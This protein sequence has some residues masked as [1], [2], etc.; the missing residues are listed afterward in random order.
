M[1]EARTY[2]LYTLAGIASARDSPVDS[3]GSPNSTILTHPS[4]GEGALKLTLPLELREPRKRLAEPEEPIGDVELVLRLLP[5]LRQVQRPGGV[6]QGTAG[7][8]KLRDADVDDT[9]TAGL[10]AADAEQAVDLTGSALASGP[11][12]FVAEAILLPLAL[13]GRAAT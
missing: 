11:G 10:G 3:R 5:A 4:P 12:E 13:G 7:L 9:L 8:H 6:G 2:S 1:T